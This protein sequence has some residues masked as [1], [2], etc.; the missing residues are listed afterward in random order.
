MRRRSRKA[1]R[2]RDRFI[3]S[4][5]SLGASKKVAK[6]AYKLWRVIS[7]W[8]KIFHS[9]LKNFAESLSRLDC[10]EI[11]KFFAGVATEG[12]EPGAMAIDVG[13]LP[14]APITEVR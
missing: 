13:L 3:R 7:E 1:R 6:A 14:A 5:M 12:D 10:P 4:A 2:R 8:L 9:A 11:R